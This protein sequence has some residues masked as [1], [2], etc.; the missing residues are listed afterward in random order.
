MLQ[1]EGLKPFYTRDGEKRFALSLLGELL[2]A[3]GLYIGR[4][5][6]TTTPRP[7]TT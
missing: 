5:F 3:Y 7:S 1:F 4:I 6:G 2:A